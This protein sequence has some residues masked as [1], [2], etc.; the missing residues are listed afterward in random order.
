VDSLHQSK[1]VKACVCTVPRNTG[2]QSTGNRKQQ[3]SK[4]RKL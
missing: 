1:P 2:N 4:C 3:T